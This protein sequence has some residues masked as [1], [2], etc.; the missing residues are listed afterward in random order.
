MPWFN[1]DQ[2]MRSIGKDPKGRSDKE[3]RDE[4]IDALY[5]EVPLSAQDLDPEVRKKIKELR[6]EGRD[7]QNDWM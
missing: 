2:A 1:E 3:L 5:S 4:A 6:R 7:P